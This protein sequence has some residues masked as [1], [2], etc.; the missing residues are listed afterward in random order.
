ML[1]KMGG[2]RR[3]PYRI[4]RSTV[5]RRAAAAVIV[6]FC[7]GTR[8]G[9]AALGMSADVDV[10]DCGWVGWVGCCAGAFGARAGEAL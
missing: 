4:L 8:A 10:G 2:K 9:H 7:A 1:V 6:S 5:T 3:R